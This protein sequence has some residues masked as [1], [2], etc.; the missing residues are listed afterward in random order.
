MQLGNQI[1]GADFFKSFRDS[2][3]YSSNFK[4]NLKYTASFMFDWKKLI[5]ESLP[6]A[7]NQPDIFYN[8][9]LINQMQKSK[10]KTSCI[11]FEKVF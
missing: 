1:P 4:A 7:L 5:D 10:Q 3:K 11:D 9:P 2:K 8:S 6:V